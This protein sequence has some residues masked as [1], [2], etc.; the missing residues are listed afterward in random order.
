[1]PRGW[2]DTLI[3]PPVSSLSVVIFLFFKVLDLFVATKLIFR[4]T[5][6]SN[7]IIYIVMYTVRCVRSNCKCLSRIG[8][9]HKLM[10]NLYVLWIL[11]WNLI[12]AVCYG[13]LLIPWPEWQ[14]SPEWLH[15]GEL[16]FEWFV[17]HRNMYTVRKFRVI[18]YSF[19]ADLCVSAL[20]HYSVNALP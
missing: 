12:S 2:K 5:Q 8:R 4:H 7:L 10:Y 14:N 13:D 11:E 3:C 15:T 17:C 20:N 19:A 9:K 18:L 1:M 6:S 16:A